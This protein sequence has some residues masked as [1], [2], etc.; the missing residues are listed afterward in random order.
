MS[1]CDSGRR[2]TRKWD[3]LPRAEL[4][5]LLEV[6]FKGNRKAFF[7]WE[8]TAPLNLGDP[9]VVE[10]DRGV[11]LGYVSAVGETA[12]RKCGVGCDSCALTTPKDPS[13][14]ILR[15]ASSEDTETSSE[16]RRS[17]DEARQKVMER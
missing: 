14:K 2:S 15:L 8:N 11:D 17:E 16:L 7:T 6:R 3:S 4:P 12:A 13:G 1:W 5:D 10:I 9:V